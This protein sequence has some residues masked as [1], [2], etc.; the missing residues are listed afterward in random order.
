MDT[1]RQEWHLDRRVTL[2]MIAALV[3]NAATVGWFAAETRSAT[4]NNTDKLLIHDAQIKDL[5][6]DNST[7]KSTLAGITQGQEF[8]LKS[9]DRIEKTI[10]KIDDRTRIGTKN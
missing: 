7:V 1:M 9:L 4:Q 2:G 6:S 10:E 8:T 3:L 5:Q